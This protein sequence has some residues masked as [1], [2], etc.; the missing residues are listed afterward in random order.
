MQAQAQ[1]KLV[2]FIGL[3]SPTAAP[4]LYTY[5]KEHPEAKV[6]LEQTYFFSDAK[7][8]A[9]G[10]AW[11]EAH[12]GTVKPGQHCG[13]LSYSYLAS[14]QAPGVIAR[15]YPS[16]RLLAVI[17][18]PLISV[19]VEYVEAK[20]RQQISS[21]TTLASFLKQFPEVLMRA[22]Y[23]RQLVHYFSYYS[24]NDFLIILAKEVRE[25]QLGTVKKTYEHL[26]L[27]PKFVPLSLRHLVV[28]EEDETK[29]RP[30][31]IK[32]SIKAIKKIIKRY[33]TVIAQKI[34]PPKVAIETA[35]TVARQIPLSPELD[36]FLKDYYRADVAQLSSL[37]HR[38][39]LVE[40]GFDE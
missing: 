12:F 40:W 17:E 29:K 35:A 28:E 31:L 19:R 27:D 11:Y 33:Y 3:G 15:I 21:D 25:D 18:N 38:N 36:Q 32:R 5:I 2:S 34:H 4:L 6:P 26:G 13:E 10:I 8:F 39:L 37:I 30:G 22:E 24:H 23:G 14:A 7:V 9:K 20:R 16:A 1:R